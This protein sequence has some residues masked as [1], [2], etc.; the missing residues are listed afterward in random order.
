MKKNVTIAVA[1]IMASAG[2]TA[3]ANDGFSAAVLEIAS[4]N[5]AIKASKAAA[6]AEAAQLKSENN[7]QDPEVEFGYLWGEGPTENK[8]N[9]SVS[10]GFD[11]PG[12]Y[13]ARSRA[14]R[15][16]LQA[17]DESFKAGV[18]MTL[19]SIRAALVD[20]VYARK[21]LALAREVNDTISRLY[22]AVSRAV[23]RGEVTRLDLNKMR[24]ERARSRKAVDDALASLSSAEN[25]LRSLNGGSDLPLSAMN[26]GYPSAR[27]LTAEEY[28]A[29]AADSH[30]MEA[31][32]LRARA[33]AEAA[34]AEG[35]QSL[36]GFSIGY[37]YENEGA[38]RWHGVNIGVTL[39]FWS[40][41]HKK[42]AAQAVAESLMYESR[43]TEQQNVSEILTEHNRAELL[44]SECDALREAVDNPDNMI[45]LGKA[46]RGGQLSLID[47]LQESDYFLQ[48]R[49][50][51]LEAEYLY[52]LALVRLLRFS[53]AGG[54]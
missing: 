11:W 6:S 30:E 9:I 41:R 32:R 13:A 19:G 38:E 23:E 42:K 26:C 49:K 7:L 33:S 40:N 54:F 50:E 37:T 25:A 24:I 8:W 35:R 14:N 31:A 16:G 20:L 36:P 51:C 52:N 29:L 10:Q 39:P 5:S 15:T 44:K 3:V 45:L 4:N 48:A 21:S 2:I 22:D 18:Q 1:I 27:L 53:S 17:V 12:V 43:V 46:L 47:Y 28:I 34:V